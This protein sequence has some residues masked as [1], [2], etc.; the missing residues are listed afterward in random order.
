MPKQALLRL[1]LFPRLLDVQTRTSA[2]AGRATFPSGTRYAL[3][4]RKAYRD[5]FAQSSLAAELRPHSTLHSNHKPEG[6]ANLPHPGSS[7]NSGPSFVLGYRG[8]LPRVQRMDAAATMRM[9]GV[10]TASHAAADIELVS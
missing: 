9:A 5:G 10:Q 1:P 3:S 4:G 8:Q 7:A 2:Y 6:T